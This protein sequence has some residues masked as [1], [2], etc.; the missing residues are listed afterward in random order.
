MYVC[1]C[2]KVV[3]RRLIK[4]VG[5]EE[6]GVGGG[7]QKSSKNIL[8]FQFHILEGKL[9]KTLHWSAK[10]MS[11]I[12]WHC[13]N[14]HLKSPCHFWCLVIPCLRLVDPKLQCSFL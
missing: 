11:V 3:I 1:R 9:E 2:I 13:K 7:L 8:W 10:A 14:T 12:R 5:M 4:R 6:V